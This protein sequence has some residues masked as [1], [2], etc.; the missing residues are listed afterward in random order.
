MHRAA[1]S[2]FFSTRGSSALNQISFCLM[3]GVVAY[4]ALC[5]AV[6]WW[7][8]SVQYFCGIV[9]PNGV[10]HTHKT[11][12]SCRRHGDISRDNKMGPRR[13][14]KGYIFILRGQQTSIPYTATHVDF[15]WRSFVRVGLE[16]ELAGI[17]CFY[18]RGEAHACRQA[19]KVPRYLGAR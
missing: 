2:P 17:G 9:L 12:H 5:L 8:A 19:R 1:L 13:V 4:D 6:V 3:T 18:E 15:A 16:Q 7:G 10:K 14:G 11:M